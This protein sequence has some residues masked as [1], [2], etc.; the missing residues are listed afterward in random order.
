MIKE[1]LRKLFKIHSPSK[2][3]TNIP[4]EEK[5]TRCDMCSYK[6]ECAPYL[7]DITCLGDTR[8]HVIKGVGYICPIDEMGITSGSID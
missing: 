3:W 4:Y 1:F 2:E 6:D 5:D 8:T 7:L